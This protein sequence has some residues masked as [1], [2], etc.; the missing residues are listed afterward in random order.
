MSRM[1]ED[2][3][4]NLSIYTQAMREVALANKVLFV[5]CFSPSRK[6]YRDGKRHTLMELST[7]ITDI[8]S[9]QSTLRN[10]FSNLPIPKKT[11]VKK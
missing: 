10:Q 2:K 9:L 7:T 6:W 11:F 5:D 3:N 1:A 4:R 8:A